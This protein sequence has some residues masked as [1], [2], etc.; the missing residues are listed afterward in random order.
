MT[1]Q[2]G[3]D[4]DL[5]R[6]VVTHLTDH[7]DVR[8][9]AKETAQQVG[10]GVADLGL[11][12]ALVDAGQF[13]LH[14][15]FDGEDAALLGVEAGEKSVKRGRFAATGRTGDQDDAVGHGEQLADFLHVF[16]IEAEA[17]EAEDL[18][19]EETQ[20]DALAID[21]RDGSNAHVDG[22]ATQLERNT[23]VLRTTVLAE[24]EPGREFEDVDD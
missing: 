1:G 22:L 6:F 4:G 8:V 15:I 5:G 23:S 16:L 12:R 19:A 7:D 14:G 3:A 18:L 17:L 24:V 9:A 11:H 2:G 10:E 13:V 20:A 21:C